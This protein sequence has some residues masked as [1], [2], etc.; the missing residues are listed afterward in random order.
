MALW[1]CA[2]P[3]Q[4]VLETETDSLAERSV[5]RSLGR[6]L[7]WRHGQGWARASRPQDGN[8]HIKHCTA[9]SH[10][11]CYCSIRC[12]YQSSIATRGPSRL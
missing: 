8:D 3:L 4:Y 12:M 5:F 2:R 11:L 1:H 6:S 10:Q 7:K 9:S